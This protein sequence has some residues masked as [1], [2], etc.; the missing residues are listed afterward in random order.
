MTGI[1]RIAA[2]RLPNY[3]CHKCDKGSWHT[4]GRPICCH[5][6]AK[7]KLDLIAAEI[8]SRISTQSTHNR[9]EG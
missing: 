1:E 3:V 8:D 6:K 2:E 4:G 5:C 7:A 9:W